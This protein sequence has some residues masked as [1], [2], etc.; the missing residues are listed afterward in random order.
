M[1]RLEDLT[2]PQKKRLHEWID[3]ALFLTDTEFAAIEHQIPMTQKLFE[4]C[5]NHCFSI[6]AQHLLIKLLNE[7][8]QYANEYLKRIKV[9]PSLINFLLK[10]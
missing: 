8:P 4:Q 7:Y 3:E 9:E 5:I 6:D 2:P 10:P 1:E